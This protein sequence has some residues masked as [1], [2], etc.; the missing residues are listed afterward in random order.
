MAKYLTLDVIHLELRVPDSLT[1]RGL[2]R[3][4]RALAADRLLPRL[5]RAARAALREDPALDTVRL[6]LAR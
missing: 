4:R 6:R 2:A 1:G 5:R 3:A